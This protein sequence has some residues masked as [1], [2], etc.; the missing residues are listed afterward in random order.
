M[1][2]LF[3]TFPTYD[4]M[5]TCLLGPVTSHLLWLWL[6]KKAILETK[7]EYVNWKCRKK[8]SRKNVVR[9]FMAFLLIDLILQKVVFEMNP[10]KCFH[11]EIYI[12]LLLL[13]FVY[14]FRDWRCSSTKSLHNSS[15]KRQ[16]TIGSVGMSIGSMSSLAPPQ[17]SAASAATNTTT[18]DLTSNRKMSARHKG[19]SPQVIQSVP[20]TWFLPC[21]TVRQIF[22]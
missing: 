18:H 1:Y 16:S 8:L 20:V 11:V 21:E 22:C 3:G 17:Q 14:Y 19:L 13:S 15:V 2:N 12:S 4:P 10:T 9:L 5:W 6:V 7:E